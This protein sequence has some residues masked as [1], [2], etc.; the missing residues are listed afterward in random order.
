MAKNHGRFR[1]LIVDDD[2]EVRR[3]LSSALKAVGFLC[4]TA[5]DGEHARK[6][7]VTQ[8]PDLIVT[9]LR[10][11]IRHGHRLVVDV[12]ERKSPPPMV[13]VVTGLV[14]PAIASDLVLRGV[15]DL[16]LKPFDAN[17]YAAK[18]L[19]MLRFRERNGVGIGS[20]EQAGN[21][22]DTG[23]DPTS[24]EK[25][26]EQLAKATD[27]LRQQLKQITA[28]FEETIQ[29][30]ES[31]QENLSADFLGS[32][33]LLTQLM[34]QFDGAEST[35]TA[36]V[37]RLAETISEP[38]KIDRD[39][40]RQV[41]LASLLHDLGMFG[42][43]DSVRVTPPSDMTESQLEAYWRYPE[44]G[45][46]LLSEVPGCAQAVHLII[47]HAEN[48]DGSGFPR[49]LRGTQIPLG[50]RII[51]LAD[52]VDTF[53][54][55]YKGA[56]A[57]DALAAHLL[58]ERGRAY[59]PE[60][61]DL[62]FEQLMDSLVPADIIACTASNLGIGDVLEQDLISPHGHIVARRGATINETMKKYVLRMM[63]DCPIRVRRADKTTGTAELPA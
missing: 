63:G 25:V 51:R 52:G 49:Q 57:D 11:P 32:V 45:A 53:V 27:L 1:A 19:A 3:S 59:D 18:W 2:P 44:I 58:E 40:L 48:F 23:G 30:L 62:S 8:S 47:S 14:E 9:D 37:E 54:M 38:A 33:R 13:V 15:A 61:V 12:F 34:R 55:H 20:T 56:G 6:M 60:L 43:P 41:R 7:L 29:E 4:E 10:M 21:D 42:M 16:V 26:T 39:F 5:A 50:A 24:H 46:T 22:L 17:V 31:K 35:H 36:R 28:S